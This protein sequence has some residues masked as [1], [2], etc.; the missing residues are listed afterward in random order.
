MIRITEEELI[1]HIKGSGG[2]IKTIANRMG[3]AWNTAQSHIEK[4]EK[5]KEAYSNELET[6]LDN[7][8]SKALELIDKGSEGM[9]KYYLSTK[10]KRRGFTER[11]E[12]EHSGNLPLQIIIKGVEPGNTDS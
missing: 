12:I 5:A 11:Q 6:V 9:I 2:I 8:E 1:E 3:C 4:S 10:G 7:V